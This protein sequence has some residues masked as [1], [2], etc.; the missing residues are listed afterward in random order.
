MQCKKDK[1]ENTVSA[2]PLNGCGLI[3]LRSCID[4]KEVSCQ[5]DVILFVSD[6]SAEVVS[7]SKYFV[8]FRY[9]LGAN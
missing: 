7:G 3:E 6:S 8:V 1:D 9:L 2:R 4:S 5:W